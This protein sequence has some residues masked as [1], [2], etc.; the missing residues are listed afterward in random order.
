MLSESC[1]DGGVLD[2]SFFLSVYGLV[3]VTAYIYPCWC[4]TSET[5]NSRHFRTFF[6]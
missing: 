6:L 3:M 2:F 1:Q 4:N 5:G